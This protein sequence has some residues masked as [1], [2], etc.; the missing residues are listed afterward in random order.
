MNMPEGLSVGGKEYLTRLVGVAEEVAALRGWVDRQRDV[1]MSL[2]DSQL[3]S[4]TFLWLDEQ[5]DQLDLVLI[6]VG[7]TVGLCSGPI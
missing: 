1:V 3:N 6:Q 4:A 2:P 5:R 7:K